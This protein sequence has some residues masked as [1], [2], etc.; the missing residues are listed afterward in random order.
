MISDVDIRDFDA[1]SIVNK[2]LDSVKE[3][4]GDKIVRGVSAAFMSIQ[5]FYL[6]VNAIDKA[7]RIS[8]NGMTEDA[9]KI[10]DQ[11]SAYQAHILRIV[12]RKLTDEQ[13]DLVMNDADR[14]RHLISSAVQAASVTKH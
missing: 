14:I 7:Y 6:M 1:T 11:F 12:C 13:R 2:E 4:H 5:Q 8:E 10:L 9:Q 3:K